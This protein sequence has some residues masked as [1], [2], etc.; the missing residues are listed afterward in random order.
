MVLFHKLNVLLGEVRVM[1]HCW[2]SYLADVFGCVWCGIRVN[3][4]CILWNKYCRGPKSA[5]SSGDGAVCTVK[6]SSNRLDT[7]CYFW[8][9]IV[10]LEVG[11]VKTHQSKMHQGCLHCQD[12]PHSSS[13]NTHR[14][15]LERF[16]QEYKVWSEMCCMTRCVQ[17]E[18]VS[19]G[20]RAICMWSG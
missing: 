7:Y 14:L 6:C 1:S 16:L 3:V 12:S 10:S 9:E 5:G 11:F 8:Q 4:H 18:D 2:C 13:R 17:I 15:K 20:R 19:Q